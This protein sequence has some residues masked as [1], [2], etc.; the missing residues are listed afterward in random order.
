VPSG[1]NTVIVFVV[2][3]VLSGLFMGT[4]AVLHSAC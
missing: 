1:D 3:M 2:L 4:C